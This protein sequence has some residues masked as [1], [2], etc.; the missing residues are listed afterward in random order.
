MLEK[1]EKERRVM[2]MLQ[3]WDANGTNGMVNENKRRVGKE[4]KKE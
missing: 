4:R 2:R 3:G 1:R